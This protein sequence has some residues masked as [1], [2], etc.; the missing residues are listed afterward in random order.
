MSIHTPH[1]RTLTAL[2]LLTVALATLAVSLTATPA[3]AAGECPNEALRAEDG[4][5]A[6]PECRAYELVSPSGLEPFGA[7]SERLGYQA[8]A[9]ADRVEFYSKYGPPPGSPSYGPYYLSSR[10]ANGWVTENVIPPQSTAS[11]DFCYPSIIFSPE[12]SQS[13]LQDGWTWA[14]GYPEHPDNAGGFHCSHDEPELVAGEPRGAQNLFLRDS[15]SHDFTL[16]NETP[17]GVP[18]RNAWYQGGSADFSHVIF[19]DPI[20]LTTGAPVPLEEPI[21]AFA[22]GEDL[23]SWARGEV[24]L[25]T[26]LPDGSPAWGLL[27]NGDESNRSRS[28][29]EW[30]HAISSDGE[31]VFFYSGGK[32]QGQGSE[33]SYVGGKLYLRENA[34]Q[35]PSAIT[36]G[37][38]SELDRACTI[39]IDESQPG[40]TG[41][42]G[43]GH[44]QWATS[45]GSKVF[46]TDERRLTLN[47]T[48]ESGKADLY[49][50]DLNPEVG[51]AGTLT[52]LSVDQTEAADVQGLSGISD[53]GAYVYFVAKGALTGAQVNSQ[54]VMAQPGGANLY[55][56]HSG[57]M[58]FIATLDG[59]GEDEQAGALHGDTCDWESYSP[60]GTKRGSTPGAP[61]SEAPNC[62]TARVSPAGQF[63]AFDSLKSLTGYDNVVAGRGGERDHE[64]FLYDAATDQ[65]RCA[66]CAPDGTPPTAIAESGQDATIQR[67]LARGEQWYEPPSYLVRNLSTSGQVFFST[68]N[69]LLPVDTNDHSDVYEYDQSQ[70]SLLSTGVGNGDAAFRD[71]SADGR[72]VF[73]TTSYALSGWDTDNGGP[74]LYDARVDGGFP[75]PPAAGAPCGSEEACHGAGAP[76]TSPSANASES[77]VGPGNLLVPTVKPAVRK[78]KAKPLTRAQKLAKALRTCHWDKSRKRRSTC[79]KSAHKRLGRSK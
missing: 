63:L 22:V 30:T 41:E 2:L 3:F 58:T 65:L 45:D 37:K 10:G 6:L 35:E 19:T 60:P 31:R 16:L 71:A 48:A 26:V 43:G 73:F 9:D 55:L 5:L 8:A 24:R 77:F 13:V 49:E 38:C 14:E 47:S 62:M 18:A 21:N 79:E 67:A 34:S 33:T 70:L 11:G 17:T 72:N 29:A 28:S 36:G 64:I 56:R 53:D 32:R 23:Y 50:Y 75:E 74:S 68:W 61:S 52:D 12:L 51:E 66:S 46:F 39:T 25:V 27:A 69:S 54:G 20:Q 40:A 4:S 78:P 76:P 15:E 42:G 7:L 59:L 57:G 1:P 44:F